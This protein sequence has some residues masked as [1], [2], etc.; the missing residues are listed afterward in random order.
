VE[1]ERK[2]APEKVRSLADGRV[3]TGEQAVQL[4]L[5]DT[6]GTYEDALR[7]AADLVGI[8]GEPAI[9]KERKRAAWYDSFFGNA[10]DAL[11]DLKQEILD[12]PVLSYRY[13]G[14]SR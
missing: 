7:I 9:V 13:P 6:I 1:H 4:G 10:G 5:V 12:R 3:F 2:L 14:P 8:T 11:R